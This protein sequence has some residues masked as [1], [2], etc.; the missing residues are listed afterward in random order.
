L[1]VVAAAVEPLLT[2]TH[3]Q[4]HIILANRV[5]ASMAAAAAEQ[6]DIMEALVVFQVEA[7]VRAGIFHRRI[8]ITVGLVAASHLKLLLVLL[9]LEQLP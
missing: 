3:P 7:Q 9:Q 5:P 1:A 4:E 6:V 2:T 8:V